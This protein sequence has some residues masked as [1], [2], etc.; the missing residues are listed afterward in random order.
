MGT[1]PAPPNPCDTTSSPAPAPTPAPT[2]GCD[3]KPA[4]WKSTAGSTCADY[5]SK[6]WCTSDGGYGSGWDKSTDGSFDDWAVNGVAATVACCGCG[7][8]S[9]VTGRQACQ[10]HSYDKATCESVGCC[11]W[12]VLLGCRANDADAQCYSG[13]PCGTTVAPGPSPPGP[14]KKGVIGGV[15][16]G[17]AALAVA[18]GIMA[19]STTTAGPGPVTTTSVTQGAQTNP[20]TT[21]TKNSS[22]DLLWLWILL[23]ILALCCLLS[24]CGGGLA[25]C[26]GGK[27]KKKKSKRATR[28]SQPSP[29]PVAMPIVEEQQELLPMVPPLMEPFPMTPMGAPTMVETVQMVPTATPTMVE[30]AVPMMQPTMLE[31]AVPMLQTSAPAAISAMPAMQ[32]GAPAVSAMPM[33]GDAMTVQVNPATAMQGIGGFGMQALPAMG[34][35]GFGTQAMPGVL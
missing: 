2:P 24:L 35:G 1:T 5:V 17:A 27:K 10:G 22:S 16:A 15:I 21:T 26:M 3:D 32:M 12:N 7:G 11:R 6:A 20:P 9:T 34:G 33:M 30:T 8:G 25:A 13:N 19:K 4:D 28:V 31:S 29:E 18:G 14:G 23:E